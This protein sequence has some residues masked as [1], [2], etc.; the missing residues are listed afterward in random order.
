MSDKIDKQQLS[1]DEALLARVEK[2][3]D[4]IETSEILRDMTPESLTERG[5][6]GDKPIDIGRG[7]KTQVT[8]KEH[9]L[10]EPGVEF[11]RLADSAVFE[12]IEIESLLPVADVEKENLIATRNAEERTRFEAG[13]NITVTISE[14]RVH[15]YALARGKPVIIKNVLHL[16]PSDVDC[17]I[18][19]R[20]DEEEMHAFFDCSPAYGSGTQ[21]SAGLVN[22]EMEQLGIRH[23]IKKE[24]VTAAVDE[25]NKGRVAVRGALVALGTPSLPGKPGTI[26]FTFDS[27]P[28]EYDFTILPDGRIDYRNSKAILTAAENQQ[29]ARIGPASPGVPGK[30]VLGE[31]LPVE[32]TEAA[33]TIIPGNGVRVSEDGK[34]FFAAIAGIIMLNGSMLDV[35]NMYVVEGDV[36]FTTGNISFNGNVLV[37]GTVLDGFEVRADG[38]VI[39]QKIVESARL[40]AG[41]DVIVKGGVLG[42]GKGL[43]SAGR[44]IRIGYAQNARLEAQGNIY[45]GNYAVNSYIATSKQ[46]IMQEKRGAVIGG[47]VFALRG[48]DIRTLGSETG[49]KTYVEA[50]TDYLILRTMGEMDGVIA[51]CEQN[52][53]KIDEALKALAGKLKSGAPLPQA[54]KRPMTKAIEKK[55]DLELRMASVLAKRA[56]LQKAS[57][58]KD[59]CFVKIKDACYTDVSI[60]IKEL[61]TIVAQARTHV[62]FYDDRKTGE[63]GVG[64]Y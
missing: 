19:I 42:R 35:V 21:L 7:A 28:R 32:D 58:E 31:S 47:E 45:I 11:E 50:G 13:N 15:Y 14:G 8:E 26:E 12:T 2:Q 9:L 64:A 10:F 27:A 63:I 6:I 53:H 1:A 30:T 5:F 3:L 62:R 60:K 46:L 36:D 18:T 44:D 29:L 33:A 41:R 49:I 40:V 25:A 54:M 16:V 59:R 52:I 55:R 48:I 34:V 4:E 24:A 38:D 17:K 20:I 57:L 56:D 37:C 43:V 22:A 61:K 51:F 23:G 39:V